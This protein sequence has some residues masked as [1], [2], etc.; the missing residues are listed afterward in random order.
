MD[1]NIGRRGLSGDATLFFSP[2]CRD[3]PKDNVLQTHD[4]PKANQFRQHGDKNK[5][6]RSVSVVSPHQWDWQELSRNRYQTKMEKVVNGV[7]TC[8]L[9]KEVGDNFWNYFSYFARVVLSL[10]WHPA[11]KACGSLAIIR[12]ENPYKCATNSTYS[13]TNV[14]TQNIDTNDSI[15]MPPT[16][17]YITEI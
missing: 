3:Y 13:K 5:R 11:V 15:F 6:D 9:N 17:N 16:K 10:H 4:A 1:A 14:W 2:S 7:R 12:F 8:A